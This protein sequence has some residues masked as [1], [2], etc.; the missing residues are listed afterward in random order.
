MHETRDHDVLVVVIHG[1][2]VMAGGDTASIV[3]M[4]HPVLEERESVVRLSAAAGRGTG[5]EGQASD[6]R[7]A[8]EMAKQDNDGGS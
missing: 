4:L 3:G 5:R 6:M 1:E 7:N 2:E 8:I